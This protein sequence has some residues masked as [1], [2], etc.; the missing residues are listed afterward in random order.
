MGDGAET[1]KVRYC[2]EPHEFVVLHG[3]ER[4]V[5]SVLS[6]RKVKGRAIWVPKTDAASTRFVQLWAATASQ[7]T[8]LLEWQAS[9]LADLSVETLRARLEEESRPC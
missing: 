1:A 5:L 3:L 4:D 2:V 6:T 7:S 9:D 8:F